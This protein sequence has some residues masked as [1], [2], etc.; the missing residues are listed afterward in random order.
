MAENLD[1]LLPVHHLLNETVFRA[2]ILLLLDEVFAGQSA[3]LHRDKQRDRNHADADQC[4]R[5]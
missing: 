2:Q 3:D 4:Q 1:D 5:P